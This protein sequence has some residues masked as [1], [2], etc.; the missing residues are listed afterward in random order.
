MTNDRFLQIHFLTSYAATLLNRDD[1]GMAKRLPF[2]G[3]VRTRVSSQCLKRHWRTAQDDHALAA[4]DGVEMSLRSRLIFQE[5]VAKPLMDE[6]LERHKVEAAVAAFQDQL[7]GSSARAKKDKA[8][9]GETAVSLETNQVVILGWPEVRFI[10][11][12]V[13]G[14]VAGANTPEAAAKGVEALFKEEG[15]NMKAL[16]AAAQ[17]PAGLDAALF[18][19]MVTSD[20]LTRLDAAIHVAHAFT[21]HTQELETDYFSALD[22]LLQESGELGSAHIN[23]SELTSGLF[24]GYVVVDVPLLVSN[25][26][27]CPQKE[28]SA[29]DRALAGQ[30]V[31]NLLHLIASV[32]PGAKKGSTAPH[33]CAEMVLVESGNRQP[34]TLANAFRH[35]VPLTGREDVRDAAMAQLGGYLKKYDAMYGAGETRRVS[36]MGEAAAL[37]DATPSSLNELAQWTADRVRGVA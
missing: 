32:S 23:D 1:A 36:T 33:A 11:E 16:I 20:L 12:K 3:A 26:T 22:D 2:G 37:G 25:L 5:K 7:L 6:G 19:R 10:Q 34:R 9:K 29:A 18:G 13:R 17:R 15:K 8:A 4:L 24:Y 14:V 31:E 21:V 30:V 35:P 28:W 27:G